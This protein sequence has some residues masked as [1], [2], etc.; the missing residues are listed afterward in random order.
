MPSKLMTKGE[1]ER[2]IDITLD[3]ETISMDLIAS[4]E[5]LVWGSHQY[6]VE[7]RIDDASERQTDRQT[8]TEK[9]TQVNLLPK[10]GNPN[11]RTPILLLLLLL[12][13]L[14]T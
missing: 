8:Q 9:E 13:Y 10:L 6:V 3:G 14:S 7:E 1:R 11:L 4:L 12:T 2:E 5:E